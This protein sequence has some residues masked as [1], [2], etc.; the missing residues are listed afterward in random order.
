MANSH[1]GAR[2]ITSNR[3]NFLL[4][5]AFLITA[6]FVAMS[7]ILHS[8]IGVTG[9]AV[10][11]LISILAITVSFMIELDSFWSVGFNYISST[12]S[13]STYKDALIR[14]T[15]NFSLIGTNAYNFCELSEF[16]E[17]T[18]RV[19]D[20]RGRVRLLLAHPHARSLIEAALNRG[21]RDKIYQ[22]NAA[23]ALGKIL[24]ISRT[25][26]G[27]VEIHLYRAE[28]I[29]DLP[30]FRIMFVNDTD[31]IASI[32]VYGRA[33]HGKSLPQI[34]ASKLVSQENSHRC[35]YS[36][37]NRYFEACWDRSEPISSEDAA[38]YCLVWETEH[39]HR[40]ER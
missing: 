40:L 24:S 5:I 18:K 37:L 13:L 10:L 25:L 21:L 32:A 4:A 16:E 36:V 11:S 38:E 7:T 6:L 2:L 3:R 1:R 8:R 27:S 34:Y 23:Y 9:V 31:A 35:M 29:E 14:A 33:D 30:I 12:I 22:E 15:T 17:M 28:R 19:R 20:S 26:G 39:N